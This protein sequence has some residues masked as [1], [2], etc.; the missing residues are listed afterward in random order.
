MLPR[1]AHRMSNCN[2]QSQSLK[3]MRQRYGDLLDCGVSGDTEG[4]D[5]FTT[6]PDGGTY[7]GGYSG[8][9]GCVFGGSGKDAGW[10]V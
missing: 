6:Y 9:A 10:V 4:D 2:H 1:L 3:Q 5:H 8:D 7:G